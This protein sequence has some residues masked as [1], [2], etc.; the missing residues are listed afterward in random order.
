M[1]QAAIKRRDTAVIH[2]WSNAR[3]RL[4]VQSP[5]RDIFNI[6]L[7]VIECP[8]IASYI[9]ITGEGMTASWIEAIRSI[10]ECTTELMNLPKARTISFVSNRSG[11]LKRS[12]T[13]VEWNS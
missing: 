5:I 13:E 2:G 11:P 3:V 6:N 7:P 10:I 4:A 1:K 9:R 12:V 8:L